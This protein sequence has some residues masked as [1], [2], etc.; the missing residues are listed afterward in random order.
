MAKFTRIISEFHGS[1]IKQYASHESHLRN[2]SRIR[3]K[4]KSRITKKGP[5]IYMV[6][7][8]CDLPLLDRLMIALERPYSGLP[9]TR[10]TH[11][12]TRTIRTT[13]KHMYTL[14]VVVIR[15]YKS[16]HMHELRYLLI[17]QISIPCLSVE[18]NNYVK[19]NILDIVAH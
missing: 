4:I 10:M 15:I 3:M 18:N 19:H 5:L 8:W 9:D 2:N 1:Q 14:I 6:C 13:R 16:H 17:S 11:T 12:Q 7:A